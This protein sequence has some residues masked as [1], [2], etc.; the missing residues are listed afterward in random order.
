MIVYFFDIHTAQTCMDYGNIVS[1]GP[2]VVARGRGKN[3]ARRMVTITTTLLALFFKKYNDLL[4]R[5]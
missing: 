2:G 5:M 3:S 4:E 1:M